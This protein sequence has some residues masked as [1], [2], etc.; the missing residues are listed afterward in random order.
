MFISTHA[1]IGTPD[2]KACTHSANRG[3]FAHLAFS[4]IV[5]NVCQC[6]SAIVSKQ[7][8]QDTNHNLGKAS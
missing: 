3:E 2:E 5:A 7:L 6:L 4:N 8:T 1:K